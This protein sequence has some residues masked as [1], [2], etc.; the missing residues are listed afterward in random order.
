MYFFLNEKEF[1]IKSY[2]RKA[3]GS[4]KTQCDG[5]LAHR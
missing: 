5:F 2:L 1:L 4:K 3:C